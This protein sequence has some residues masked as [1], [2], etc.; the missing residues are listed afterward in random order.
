M[1]PMRRYSPHGLILVLAVIIYFVGSLAPFRV[2]TDTGFQLRSLQ[3][4]ERGESTSP[5]VLSLPDPQ[6]LSHDVMLWSNWWPP[7]FPFLYA[8]LVAADLPLSA[9]LR[10]TSFLLFLI[11]ALGWLGL[12]NRLRLPGWVWILYAV[13]L[14]PYAVTIGGASALRSADILSFACGPWLA[15]LA[16]SEGETLRRPARLLI[17]GLAFGITYWLKYTLFLTALPLI[18]FLAFQVFSKVRPNR[19]R[20]VGIAALG[21]GFAL[22]VLS[23]FTFNL[24]QVANLSEGMTGTRSAWAVQ[25][26]GRARA[27]RPSLL[28]I[29]LAGAPGLALFQN[30]QWITHAAY[31]SDNHLPALRGRDDADRL[32]FKSLLALPG[33]AALF[34]ALLRE[35]RRSSSVAA[36]ALVVTTGFYLELLGVSLF[37][38][39]NY[40]ANEARLAV[41]F[42]PLIAPLVLAGWLLR[43]EG[44]R[45]LGVVVTVL[46]VA[47]SLAFIAANFV[48]NEILD[49]RSPSYLSSSTGLFMPELST[50]N[51]PEV[52]AAVAAARRSPRDVIVLAG[53]AGWGSPFGVWLE[54]PGRTLPMGTFYAPLGAR[55][56]EA[57]NLNAAAPLTSSQPL[58]VVLVVA[59]SLVQEGGLGRI[60]ARFP[61]ARTWLAAAV[62]EG[63]NVAI[64]W[65]DLARD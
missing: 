44:L 10:A 59:R 12:M 4:W 27:A 51:V 46:L 20:L 33:A 3:Q 54:M 24:R 41:G 13:S 40:L 60:E 63:S 50:R 65:S 56:L 15:R 21:L 47:P 6:D 22:P 39:Y 5:G 2:D 8:P 64:Y 31:F 45:P 28:A 32:L 38:G 18:A 16:L 14:V 48:K 7:G 57:A 26:P 29:S 17:C 58:R 36:L 43:G 23:L 52:L 37:V 25:D 19:A 53:P 61:Q 34:W 62:P 35:R 55:Y 30:D 49:R 42:M 11:G 1:I 9:A